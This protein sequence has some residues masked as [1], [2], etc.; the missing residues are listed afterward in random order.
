MA[1]A[2]AGS[3]TWLPLAIGGVAVLVIGF[4]GGLILRRQI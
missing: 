4:A 1:D 3:T 2:S